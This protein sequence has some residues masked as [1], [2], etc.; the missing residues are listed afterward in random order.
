M[1]ADSK[2]LNPMKCPVCQDYF[3]I[4]FVGTRFKEGNKEFGMVIPYFTCKK[5]G[6]FQ[7]I[8]P[9]ST[10]DK[11]KATVFPDME[12]GE[13]W[14][15][16]AEKTFPI[17]ST[18]KKFK[19]FSHLGFTYDPRDYYLIPGLYREWDEGYLE[20]VFFD[21]D[22]LLHYNSHPDYSVKLYSFSEGNIFYKGKALFTWGFGINR[23]GKIFKWLGD[24]NEDF[25]PVKM[26][27][28]L[29]RFQASNIKSDHDI[30]STFYFSQ[31]LLTIEDA[32]PV[33]DNE[34]RLFELKNSFDEKVKAVYD[35]TISKLDIRKLQ[36]Y[37]KHPVLEE[38][39]Q[40]F[41]A[42]LSLTK[43]LIE[44]L[45]AT[46]ITKALKK[47][48]LTNSDLESRGKKLGTLKLFGLFIRH[49]LGHSNSDKL[50]APLFVLYD[51]RLLHGHLA[52]SSYDEKYTDCKLRLGVT[53]AIKDLDFFK[54]VITKL[55][56]LYSLL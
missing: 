18:R 4:E 34:R 1:K 28:H 5:C 17:L 52:G 46:E 51:L 21:S 27:R 56:E 7:T 2:N 35:I 41:E 40:I 49:V 13:Q 47:V 29:K 39:G 30:V 32:F 19:R 42:Y 12:E 22:L 6:H 3:Y 55:I 45:Q 48:G 16:K 31:T 44:N 26:K 14:R 33:S 54:V 20:P 36:D 50:I 15:L 10:F 38:R 25:E 23:S 43:F 9:E 11:L 8:I 53:K 24:L 37:Y